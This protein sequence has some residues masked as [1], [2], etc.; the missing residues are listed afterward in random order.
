MSK[1]IDTKAKFTNIS[2]LDLEYQIYLNKS[3]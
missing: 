1:E 2:T 3:L